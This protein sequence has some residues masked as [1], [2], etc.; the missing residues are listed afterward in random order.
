MASLFDSSNSNNAPAAG[1]TNNAFGALFDNPQMQL[2]LSLLAGSTSANPWGAAA[3]Q[4]LQYSDS[5]GKRKYMQ[6]L[7]DQEAQRAAMDR[8]RLDLQ[9]RQMQDWQDFQTG[10]GRYAPQGT[11]PQGGSVQPFSGPQSARTL[12]GASMQ[13][14]APQGDVGALGS[15]TYQPDA[16]TQV[17]GML[18]SGLFGGDGLPQ[19][20]SR[21]LLPASAASG[22]FADRSNQAGQASATPENG[23]VRLTAPQ[24]AQPAPS[25]MNSPL[26]MPPGGAHGPLS[27]LGAI[28]GNNATPLYGMQPAAQAPSMQP[29]DVLDRQALDAPLIGAGQTAAGAGM[30]AAQEAMQR[31]PGAAPGEW[32]ALNARH[33]A[34]A[35]QRASEQAAI[36]QDELA[37]E[38]DPSNRAALQRE[39][40][41][42]QGSTGASGAAGNSAVGGGADL[43]STYGAKFDDAANAASNLAGMS[44]A[45]MSKM[46]QEGGATKKAGQ[47]FTGQTRNF[48]KSLPRTE[49]GMLD[50][51]KMS[52]SQLYSVGMVAS[53]LGQKD[54]AALFSDMAGKHEIAQRQ[55]AQIDQGRYEFQHIGNQVV[56]IDKTGQ[57]PAQVEYVAKSEPDALQAAKIANENAQADLNRARAAQ[58]AAGKPEKAP[59]LKTWQDAAG[60]VFNF[61][62]A[63]GEYT[64]ATAGGKPLQGAVRSAAGKGMKPLEQQ[65]PDE[66]SAQKISNTGVLNMIDEIRT[67]P[68]LASST[69]FLGQLQGM[70]GR[71]LG[72]DHE[73]KGIGGT[74]RYDIA[75]KIESVK[76]NA[77]IQ[78]I[79]EAAKK[80]VSLYPLSDSDVKMVASN[81][82]RLDP[83]MSKDALVESLGKIANVYSRANNLVDAEM[84]RRSTSGASP[85]APNVP[86]KVDTVPNPMPRN[87]LPER[88]LQPA[89]PNR[90]SL[91][92][93]FGN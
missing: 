88:P 62:P 74:P 55:Q 26:I 43:R 93:I 53:S 79:Q 6:A 67:D 20:D 61:N 87:D 22:L 77:A 40:A 69:G 86:G 89:N 32:S 60:N 82:A 30:R 49:D 71:A 39:L 29:G 21:R 63:T 72:M 9:K 15:G 14:N 57:V 85:A 70:A 46:L 91:S 47:E 16:Q 4:M 41:R 45:D 13:E 33:A 48:F 10:Q 12:F 66:L 5:V 35:P 65:S 50:L 54:T 24:A 27:A 34:A 25:D 68:H 58:V 56:R 42:V 44:R 75:S 73:G 7:A 28:Y 59:A 17:R 84:R 52:P 37:K 8:E 3:Q 11:A 19:A 51:E 80:G 18:G 83:N 31:V 36:L 92:S 90:P 64:P 78:A 38:T 1:G 81:V 23:A 76:S 2:G